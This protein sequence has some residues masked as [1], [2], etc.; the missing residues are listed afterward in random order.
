MY[1]KYFG[2]QRAPF[3]M[4]PDPQCVHVAGQHSDAISGAVFGILERRGCIVLTGEAGLG[5]TSVLRATVDL[6]S[7][8]KIR[9]SL[10]SHPTL[11]ASELLELALINFGI[12]PVPAS[13]ALRLKALEEF[14][15]AS[16]AAGR[17]CVLIIDEAHMLPAPALEEIRLLGNLEAGNQKL[18]Q[19]LLAGQN[20]LNTRLDS[21]ELWQFKQRVAVRLSLDPLDRD[22]VEDYIAFRWTS[23]GG[24]S[25][26]FD[27]AAVSAIA[28]WSHGIPRVINAI[29]DNAL[30]LA[31]SDA[32]RVVGV[33][34]VQDV[35]T[36]LRFETPALAGIPLP[37]DPVLEQESE[38]VAV[39]LAAVPAPAA[40]A[41]EYRPPVPGPV[42]SSVVKKWLGK[43][44]V[45]TSSSSPGNPSGLVSLKTHH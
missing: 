4:V 38:P 27:P 41:H 28:T 8:S 5:K 31:L 1:E 7:D 18:L 36:D 40:P 22:A 26:P 6:L 33:N 15:V 20:E 32:V 37:S 44:K 35:C 21:P 13:K 29:C 14:L 30:M 12:Q 24:T 34:L 42:G 23:A 10:I 45:Q 25:H 19:I 39:P 3:S 9:V 16:D 17:I 11:D 2:V 43:L